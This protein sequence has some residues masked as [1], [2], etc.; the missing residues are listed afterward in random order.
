M[1]SP[2]A[3]TL[4]RQAAATATT[5]PCA[6]A[7]L[8]LHTPLESCVDLLAAVPSDGFVPNSAAA[9]LP[10]PAGTP[11]APRHALLSVR[12][13]FLGAPAPPRGGQAG[14]A[15]RRGRPR[16]RAAGVPRGANDRRTGQGAEEQG[17]RRGHRRVD[18]LGDAAPGVRAA[19]G[20]VRVPQR[21]AGHRRRR[22][23]LRLQ[24]RWDAVTTEAAVA[25][26]R[27]SLP[28]LPPALRGSLQV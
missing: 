1:K 6:R 14:V 5:F 8:R 25:L 27:I 17:A 16:A 10:S 9:L 3:R 11:P 21:H 19:V 23:V 22:P 24:R 15:T 28:M 12:P 13:R 26:A 7:H 2:R 18:V 4:S 20:L